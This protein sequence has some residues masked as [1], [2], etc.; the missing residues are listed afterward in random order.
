MVPIREHPVIELSYARGPEAPVLEKTIG[1][2]LADTVAQFPER[3]ALIARHQNV[4][5]SWREFD[6]EIECTARGLAGLGL[7]P[8]DR[9]GIWSSNC[10]EWVL[11][12]LACA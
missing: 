7:Q 10:L 4:R 5:L 9:V 3:E 12:Q 6:R 1:Q 11:L 8:Q 2:A